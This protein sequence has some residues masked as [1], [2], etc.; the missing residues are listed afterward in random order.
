MIIFL[1]WS[2]NK[3]KAAAEAVCAFFKKLYEKFSHLD[4]YFS[5]FVEKGAD[6]NT[7]LENTLAEADLGLLFL[8]EEN[9]RNPSPWIMY[10]AGVLS[11]KSLLPFRLN[12]SAAD[13]PG[14][15]SRRQSTYFIAKGSQENEQVDRHNRRELIALSK[16]VYDFYVRIHPE[17]AGNTVTWENGMKGLAD[18]LCNDLMD[19]LK[20]ASQTEENEG[21][22]S[23]TDK[24][25]EKSNRLLKI[26]KENR[27]LLRKILTSRPFSA[28]IPPLNSDGP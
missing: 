14:A 3:S 1:S 20:E 22:P 4:I 18:Y 28:G 8:T 2:G 26:S 23:S 25:L 24:M 21:K 6:W 5:P 7:E 16:Q 9:C 27:V 11:T 19:E 17:D 13:V 15:I 12:V 10:E